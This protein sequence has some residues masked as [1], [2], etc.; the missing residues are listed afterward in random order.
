MPKVERL[1][2]CASY[3]QNLKVAK[4]EK[5]LEI[6]VIA[7]GVR[8]RT[9]HGVNHEWDNFRTSSPHFVRCSY[10]SDLDPQTPLESQPKSSRLHTADRERHDG[11]Q[12]TP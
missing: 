1:R 4:P 3:S 10:F 5:E 7:H 6:A 2:F 8:L 12:D 9:K 11:G